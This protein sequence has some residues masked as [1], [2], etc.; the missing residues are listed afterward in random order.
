MSKALTSIFQ[1]NFPLDE[2][3]YITL[4]FASTLERSV[5]VLPM[6]AAL[7][8]SH[9]RISAELFVQTL[10]TQF[11]F[12]ASIKI[13]QLSNLNELRN[14]DFDVVFATEKISGSYIQISPDF[15][16]TNM[17]DVAKQIR[18]IH[19]TMT[20]QPQQAL[21]NFEDVNLQ[22]FLNRSQQILMDFNVQAVDNS[23]DFKVTVRQSLMGVDAVR[24]VDKVVKVLAQRFKE[25][26]FGIPGTAIAM[27]HGIDDAVSKPY[28][29][30]VDLAQPLEVLCIDRTK[31]I[32]TR[33][34]ILI[35]PKE[36][37]DISNSIIGRIASS[38][39]EH[40]L[41]TAIYRSGNYEIIY[42][43]LNK[44]INETLRNYGNK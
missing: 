22:E 26:P 41:Y 20:Q 17:T 8:T 37:D 10:K 39:V 14:D 25:T 3:A 21:D 6:R 27:V 42:E 1:K 4:H 9:G 13:Y 23:D 7:V 2:V 38:I 28:F 40:S 36:V 18:K 34:L 31:M 44:I 5:T 33:L 15:E 29:G 12:I 24:D 19:N 16:I 43:L 30:V 11:P 35:A 32:A